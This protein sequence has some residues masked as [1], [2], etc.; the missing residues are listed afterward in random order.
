MPIRTDE[1][2]SKA[3]LVRLKRA[4]RTMTA[5]WTKG[6]LEQVR[7]GLDGLLRL[8]LADMRSELE[9]TTGGIDPA[10]C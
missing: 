8:S 7:L 3:S 1:L 4:G 9:H 2:P 5:L 6:R 10:Q